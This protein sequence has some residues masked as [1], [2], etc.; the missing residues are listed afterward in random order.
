[1]YRAIRGH[2]GHLRFQIAPKK[3]A[4]LFSDYI[5]GIFVVSLVFRK[6]VVLKKSNM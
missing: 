1:M 3:N 2:G 5:R 4:T 6:A